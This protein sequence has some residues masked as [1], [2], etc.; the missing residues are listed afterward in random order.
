MRDRARDAHL[1][2]ELRQARGVGVSVVGQELQR[3]RLFELEVVGAIDL[4][5]AAAAEQRDDAV[6]AGEQRA[7]REP[8]PAGRDEAMPSRRASGVASAA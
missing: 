6:A 3:D 5:H 1:V 8:P 2:V 4:A 7:G